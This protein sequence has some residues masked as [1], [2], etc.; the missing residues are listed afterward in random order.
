MDSEKNES[1]EVS[2]SPAR[3]E[4]GCL[5][6]YSTNVAGAAAVAAAA[7]AAHAVRQ[8]RANREQNCRRPFSASFWYSVPPRRAAG[9]GR[10]GRMSSA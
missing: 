4:R 7:A 10:G 1:G 6:S 8:H 9:V 5:V 2:E 3:S